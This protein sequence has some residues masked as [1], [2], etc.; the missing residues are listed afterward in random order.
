MDESGILKK[1]FAFEIKRPRITCSSEQR[2]NLKTTFRGD[3]NITTRTAKR[4]S[5]IKPVCGDI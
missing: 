4:V 1:N 5:D 2:R 3:I